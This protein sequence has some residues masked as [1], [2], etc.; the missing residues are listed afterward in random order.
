MPGFDFFVFFPFSTRSLSLSH[1]ILFLRVIWSGYIAPRLFCGVC[2]P[3][4]VSFSHIHHSLVLRQ[5]TRQATICISF[6]CWLHFLSTI[7]RT[8]NYDNILFLFLPY[9]HS[10]RPIVPKCGCPSKCGLYSNQ[11]N[12]G[13]QQCCAKNREIDRNN[14]YTAL[15][16]INAFI[17]S[18][19][20]MIQC[21]MV[22]LY[23]DVQYT[24]VL[25]YLSTLLFSACH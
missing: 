1:Q 7:S 25:N 21:Q 22:I 8:C 12:P 10:F 19:G 15:L 16:H 3:T 5:V 14:L 11:P 18:T 9:S 20:V 6:P 4:K 24:M 17:K 13:H 23:F 2:G